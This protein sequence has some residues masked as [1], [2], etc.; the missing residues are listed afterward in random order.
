M[1]ETASPAAV[2]NEVVSI[3]VPGT[4]NIAE[5][6]FVLA[7]GRDFY[8]YPRLSP[9][10]SHLCYVCW[11][12]PNMPWDNTELYIQPLDADGRPGRNTKVCEVDT[13][14]SHSSLFVCV[15]LCHFCHQLFWI[16]A[17]QSEKPYWLVRVVMNP[18]VSQSGGLTAKRCC[19]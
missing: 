5:D 10:G 2:V 15:P 4:G 6:T 12:H 16:I 7:T 8:S 18:C 9:S 19:I 11:D 14:P 1:Q 13:K 17:I 3:S